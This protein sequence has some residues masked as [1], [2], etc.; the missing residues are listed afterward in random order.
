MMTLLR[1]NEQRAKNAILLLGIVIAV[2]ILAFLSG[3]F[4]LILLQSVASGDNVT[5]ETAEL[6]DLREL[7][8]AILSLIVLVISGITFIMWFR[9][10]YFNL[11]LFV[12]Y[13]KYDEGWASGSW[14]VPFINLYR[15][16][17]IMKELF[18]ETKLILLK[19]N[20]ELKANLS[21]L[22]VE[23]WW[24]FWILSG[25][26][27]QIIYRVLSNTDNL[28]TIITVSKFDLGLNIF[29][30]ISALIA[31]KVVK[32]YAINEQL[33]FLISDENE[34]S[35]SE[36]TYNTLNPQGNY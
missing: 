32:D 3:Y 18:V 28:E 19:N 36:T 33:L 9:R 1:N 29:T 6:N 31:I 7:I 35:S 2:E 24:I 5:I 30:I 14:F 11:H 27:G 21:S 20:I 34:V 25:L 4:Q 12:S 8:M 26:F 17:K 10:A 15:P 22:I 16:Y 23:F 13:L